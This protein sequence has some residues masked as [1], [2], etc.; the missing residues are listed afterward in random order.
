MPKWYADAM[1][2]STVRAG[3]LV[4]RLVEDDA[5]DDIE[6]RSPAALVVLCH[7]YGAPGTDLVGLAGELCAIEP[8][9]KRAR[10]AFPEAPHTLENAPFGGRAW[11]EIDVGRF[12]SAIAG[13]TLERLFEETP[14]GLPRA[15][16]LLLGALEE[17]ERSSGGAPLVLGGFSQGAMLATDTALRRDEA[18]AALAIF[19]GT[20]LSKPQWMELARKRRDLPVLQ[21]HGTHDPI[22]PYPAALELKR[23]LE[24]A[25]LKVRFHSFPGGHGLDADALEL[26]AAQLVAVIE[27]AERAR[28]HA[29]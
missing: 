22:V 12:T 26:F 29:G 2:S 17:L 8:R 3:G 7:G 6:G 13:G 19:S 4:V 14:E 21:C 20:L 24:D 1:K 9:L 16:K 28:A 15:R 5:K 23:I 25:G 18:P 11:W 27:E 10:F